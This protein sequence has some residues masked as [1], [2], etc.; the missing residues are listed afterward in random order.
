MDHTA[1]RAHIRQMTP[2]LADEAQHPQ[3]IALWD[4]LPTTG[5]V[6]QNMLAWACFKAEGSALLGLIGVGDLLAA[7]TLVDELMP[8]HPAAGIVQTRLLEAMVAKNT[9]N[10]GWNVGKAFINAVRSA[11]LQSHR[12]P[13]QDRLV[14]LLDF[15]E[16]SSLKKS[17]HYS[18]DPKSII[19]T[20]DR[21]GVGGLETML[22]R[23]PQH[24]SAEDRAVLMVRAHRQNQPELIPVLTK[25]ADLG[26]VVCSVVDRSYVDDLVSL[27]G[28]S[29]ADDDWACVDAMGGGG[30]RL[31]NNPHY[32][33]HLDRQAMLGSC[34]ADQALVRKKM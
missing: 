27:V 9:N 4:S 32:R 16:H 18:F 12:Q 20:I 6:R 30:A 8:D 10:G 7:C 29:M 22:E 3:A 2:L 25:G 14:M 5:A 33:S 15:I 1:T 28:P 19:D 11:A 24:F 23:W 21:F 26:A 17:R 13:A 31:E 34:V